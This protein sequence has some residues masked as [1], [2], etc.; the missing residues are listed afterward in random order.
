MITCRKFT[1]DLTSFS[2]LKS[3]RYLELSNT[4]FV[5]LTPFADIKQL[6]GLAL[7]VPS[8]RDLS[9]LAK[10]KNLE[11]LN[12]RC[13]SSEAITPTARVTNH[14]LLTFEGDTKEQRLFPGVEDLEAM[15]F[16]N[17]SFSD[18]TPLSGLNDLNRVSDAEIKA[19]K[20]ALPRCRVFVKR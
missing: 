4:S 9:P 10:L 18:P 15:S 13:T 1:S 12:I 14:G 8:I 7:G 2:K 16:A 19:L 20:Q 11:W 6:R 5:D 17:P 3:L